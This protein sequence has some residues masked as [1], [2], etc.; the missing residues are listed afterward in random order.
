VRSN[1]DCRAGGQGHNNTARGSETQAL[2]SPL[3]GKFKRY[4]LGR[5]VTFQHHHVAVPGCALA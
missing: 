3:G 1:R 2:T 5:I 4:I